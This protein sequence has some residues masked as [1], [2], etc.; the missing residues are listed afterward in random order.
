MIRC[1]MRALMSQV[2]AGLTFGA[3]ALLLL[4]GL[5]PSAFV[6]LMVT[7]DAA[8][9]GAENAMMA[10]IMPGDTADGRAL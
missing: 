3:W 7:D 10:G 2:G 6:R 4:L 9:A 8:G 1:V 5:F